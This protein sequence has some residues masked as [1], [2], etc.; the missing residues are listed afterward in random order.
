VNA[1]VSAVSGVVRVKPYENDTDIVDDNGIVPHSIAL[2]VEG[3][4]ATMIADAIRTKKGGGTGTFGTSTQIVTD[5]Q[6]VTYL[7]R[8][9]RPD[10]VTTK[11]QIEIKALTGYTST[12]GAQLV[13][14][15]A[16]Y[17]N[18]LEIGQDVILTRLFMPANLYGAANSALFEVLSG[19]ITIAKTADSLAAAD[20]QIAYN[21][22]ATITTD[23]IVLVVT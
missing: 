18:A 11:A 19:G 23:D 20:I 7:I 4:D 14:A 3:G 17:I 15:V 13:A 2:V 5:D 9:S 12:I 16:D 1:A 22:R 21:E 10:L 8:F 6:G